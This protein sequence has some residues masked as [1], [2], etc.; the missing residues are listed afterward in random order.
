MSLLLRPKYKGVCV[1]KWGGP[2]DLQHGWT[3]VLKVVGASP[4]PYWGVLGCPH[5]DSCNGTFRD[6]PSPLKSCW[7]RGSRSGLGAPR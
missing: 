3:R 1:V 2:D 6:R 7:Y 5:V 4:N